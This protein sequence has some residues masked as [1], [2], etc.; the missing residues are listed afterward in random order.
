MG[1]GFDLIESNVTSWQRYA[2]YCVDFIVLSYNCQKY[3]SVIRI[4]IRNKM[5]LCTFYTLYLTIYT[6][7]LLN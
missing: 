2:L 5:A 3:L 4:H 6:V 7:L 1:C